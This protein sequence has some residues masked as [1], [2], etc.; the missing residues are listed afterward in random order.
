MTNWVASFLQANTGIVIASRARHALH[1]QQGNDLIAH[2][3]GQPCHFFS[4]GIW[5]PIDTAL[6]YDSK[7]DTYGAPGI[8]VRLKADGSVSVGA[9]SQKTLAVGVLDDAAKSFSA[10][11]TLPTGLVSDDSLIRETQDYR[12]VLTLKENGL[13]EE[14]ILLTKPTLGKQEDWFVLETVITGKAL[15]SGWTDDFSAE[16]MLFPPPFVVDAK[17]DTAQAR[18]FFRNGRLYTGIQGSWLDTAAYPVTIDPDFAGSTADGGI[19]GNNADY[20]T[21][22]AVASSSSVVGT[23]IPL[24][25]LSSPSPTVYRGFFKFD[26]SSIGAGSTVTQVNLKLV[27]TTDQSL[28]DLDV[29]IVKQDWSAQDPIDA[30][31]REAAYDNCLS[32]TADDAIWRNT[33]GMSLNTQYASGNLSTAWP[34]KTGNTYYSLRSSRDFAGTAPTGNEFI[35]IASADHATEAYRPVLTVAYS[36]GGGGNPYYAYAQQ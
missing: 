23:T 2:I 31:N 10:V 26:T 22:R 27:A 4:N 11:A 8:P 7:T 25:Q 35:Y 17:G 9:Y 16:G 12:H 32:G 33:S 28:T 24:G 19:N 14:L 30:T 21:A 15:P 6:V 36:A 20:A 5:Q 18:R 1:V 29:Q 3:T 34:S 13:R